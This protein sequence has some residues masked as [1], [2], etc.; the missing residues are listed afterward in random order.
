MHSLTVCFHKR[1]PHF[2]GNGSQSPTFIYLYLQWLKCNSLECFE[3][4]N[5]FYPLWVWTKK[6]RK[7]WQN[8]VK[9]PQKS[10]K[11]GN[12]NRY[13]ASQTN[14]RKCHP[15]TTLSRL[16]NYYF[17][18]FQSKQPKLIPKNPKSIDCY[19]PNLLPIFIAISF[20]LKTI[21][22]TI[23]A[24]IYISN[25][26]NVFINQIDYNLMAFYIK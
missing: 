12:I 4:K 20:S 10:R 14:R 2:K 7:N 23:Y 11:F 22:R 18:T 26:A 21:N 13:T 3:K 8:F 16:Q 5:S 15:N 9:S 17:V 19:Y 25:I 1:F 24:W 6:R